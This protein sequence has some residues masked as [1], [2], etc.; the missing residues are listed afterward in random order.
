MINDNC[1]TTSG[2]CYNPEPPRLWNRLENSCAYDNP[3]SQNIQN[4]TLVTLP[5]LNI[6]VP[7][8][9]YAVRMAY[10]NK[11]NVLQYKKNAANLTKNQIY[12]RIVHDLWTNRN[13]SWATQNMSTGYT[14]PNSQSLKRV[15]NYENIA[16]RKSDNSIIGKT[17]LAVTCKKNKDSIT[18]YVLPDSNPV[19]PSPNKPPDVLPPSVLPNDNDIIIP[20]RP[21]IIPDDFFVIPDGGKLICNTFEDVCTGKIIEGNVSE[22]DAQLTTASDVPGNMEVLYWN[23][24]IATWYPRQTYTMSTSGNKFPMNSKDLRS[25]VNPLPATITNILFDNTKGNIELFWTQSNNCIIVNEYD[26][27]QNDVLYI[28]FSGQLRNISISIDINA[29]QQTTYSYFLIGRNGKTNS[30]MSNIVSI[31]V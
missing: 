17:N 10:L 6:Q 9:E 28:S 3:N 21:D 16:I 31:T 1:I 29:N 24:G 15:G 22:F 13:T 4:N 26:L 2:D 11:G 25:A 23:D 7:Y 5:L 30:K 20:K 27:Y 19:I 12:S 18:N 8:S 14:N